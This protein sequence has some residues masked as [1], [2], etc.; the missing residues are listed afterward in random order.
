MKTYTLQIET[1]SGFASAGVEF[2]SMRKTFADGVVATIKAFYGGNK[3][4]YRL[5][6]NDFEI[7]EEFETKSQPRP[8]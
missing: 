2:T 4:S 6:S 1:G 3:R 7:I 8:S 5:I